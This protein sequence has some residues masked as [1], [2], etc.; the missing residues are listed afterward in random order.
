MLVNQSIV[1]GVFPNAF[2]LGYITPIHKA[3]CKMDV[4]NYRPISI[5]PAISKIIE[6]VV[7]LQMT[8]FLERNKLLSPSQ[9]GFRKGYS[10]ESACV[11]LTEFLRHNIDRGGVVGAVFLDLRKA[12]DMIS[13]QKL[14]LKLQKFN[15]AAKSIDWI[16]SYLENR[17]QCVKI[18]NKY[19]N[20]KSY[21]KGVPQG[22]RIS[23]I[24]FSL[25]INDLPNVCPD[26]HTQMYA[27]DTAIFYHG[28][29]P[30]EVAVALSKAMNSISAWLTKN[31]LSL[32]VDKTVA[33]YFGKKD[34]PNP[35]PITVEGSTLN[36]VSSVKYLGVHFDST[37]KF[38]THIQKLSKTMNMTLRTFGH[39]RKSFSKEAA[40]A[41]YHSMISSR[42]KYCITCWSQAP[43]TARK[44]LESLYKRA[45]KIL[46]KKD[47]DYH[48]C[49][50]YNNCGLLN[51][52]NQI[53]HS[54]LILIHKIINEG[55]SPSLRE[56]IQPIAST[57][58]R[59]TRASSNRDCKIPFRSSTFGQAAWSVRGITEW[60]RLPSK[61]KSIPSTKVFSSQL[62][63]LL[64]GKQI[65][66]CF[67]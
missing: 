25:Y 14:L 8:D 24:L 28:K 33:I 58:A 17:T 10:T 55:A 53:I 48:H 39:V 65:C 21:P 47:W 29:D 6:K 4:K 27:D 34:L 3:G 1:E 63:Q 61:L 12:F 46:D 50:V 41:F 62:K 15:F 13:H 22:S 18:N 49:R 26:V 19:S 52:D 44:T 36:T 59:V 45:A 5:L 66:Q 42:F 38:K 31:E 40:S 37:L 7:T 9:Y 20:F 43:S 2:K 16:R 64:L 11:F 56:Y 60:N 35:P 32:N 51:T 54:N 67:K 23:P 30:G 57:A